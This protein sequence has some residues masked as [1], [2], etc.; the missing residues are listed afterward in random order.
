VSL[1]EAK[2]FSGKYSSLLKVLHN[3]GFEYKKINGRKLLLERGDIAALRNVFLQK[4]NGQDLMN[5][6]W[7]DETWVNAN[8]SRSKGW[9]DDSLLGTMSIP[10]GRGGRLIICHARTASGFVCNALLLFKSRKTGSYHEEMDGATFAKWFKEQ[11]IPNIPANTVIVMDNAPYHSVQ[12]DR[13]PT[14][15]NR[16]QD[17]ID[18]LV[19]HGVVADHTMSKGRLLGLIHCNKPITPLYH[20]DE[21]AKSYGHEVIRLPPYHCHFN[22]IEII[23]SYVKGYVADNKKKFTMAEVERLTREAIQKITA[24]EWKKAVLHVKSEINEAIVR[25]G[26]LDNAVDDLIIRL[27]ENS[28]TSEDESSPSSDNDVDMDGFEP[29]PSDSP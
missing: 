22:P 2:L 18:W 17:M 10:T 4:I 8:H 5:I 7:V 6:V 25:E 11:L 3:L 9:T 20:I 28:S 19:R 21:V 23:W 16:K 24:E 15:A 14:N 13:A 26:I 29:L 27:E 1:N 12:V